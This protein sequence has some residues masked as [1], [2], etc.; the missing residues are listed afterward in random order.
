ML[1]LRETFGWCNV[2][3]KVFFFKAHLFDSWLGKSILKKC[4]HSVFYSSKLGSRLLSV[5][6]DSRYS[7]DFALKAHLKSSFCI[8]AFHFNKTLLKISRIHFQKT[9]RSSATDGHPDPHRRGL[10]RGRRRGRRRHA[11]HHGRRRAGAQAARHRAHRR[12]PLR[13]ALAAL[14]AE[15]ERAVG[16]DER[17]VRGGAGWA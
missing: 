13:A 5:F 11:H 1:L 4:D 15:G 6:F 8:I 17:S 16:G 10:G 9:R 14:A 7:S 3:E 2:T 12:L